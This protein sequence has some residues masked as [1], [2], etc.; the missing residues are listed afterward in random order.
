MRFETPVFHWFTEKDRQRQI[1]QYAVDHCGATKGQAQDRRA[2]AAI[3]TFRRQLV[4]EGRRSSPRRSRRVPLAVVL[5]GRPLPHRSPHQP[6][7]CP[8]VHPPGHPGVDGGQSAGTGPADLHQSRWRSPM[9]SC[10]DA[11]RRH[12]DGGASLTGVCADRQ[13]LAVATMPS[14]PM[15]S[16]ACWGEGSGKPPLILKVDESEAAGSPASA[17]SPSLRR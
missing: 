12:G 13:F 15:R 8:D 5:A 16:S 11:L 14:C 1:C 4:E 6:R 2:A 17:C 9:I 10:P 3:E 7:S